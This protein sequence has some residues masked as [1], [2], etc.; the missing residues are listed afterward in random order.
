MISCCGENFFFLHDGVLVVI[1]QLHDVT[2]SEQASLP[3]MSTDN[4]LFSSAEDLIKINPREEKLQRSD[5]TRINVFA[6]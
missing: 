5:V 2:T 1:S 4:D 6:L 3:V